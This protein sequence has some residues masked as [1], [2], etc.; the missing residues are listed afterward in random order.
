M[1]NGSSS[2]TYNRTKNLGS[3]MLQ[4]YDLKVPNSS[5]IFSL[6]IRL[7][8]RPEN[9]IW[10]VYIPTTFLIGIG[11]GTL[12]LPVDRFAERGGMSLTTLLVLISL[13]TDASSRLPE[14]TYLKLMDVWF[15]F[16][17]FFLSLI[18]TVHLIT[19][20]DELISRH[21]LRRTSFLGKMGY[22]NRYSARRLVLARYIFGAVFILFFLAYTTVVIVG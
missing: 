9:H 11:Y 15:V 22:W 4:G 20:K 17:I 7:V 5:N 3:Y 10:I 16:T 18:I 19:C 2:I 8:Q 12:F 13:Y 14:T 21:S 1:Y 6:V